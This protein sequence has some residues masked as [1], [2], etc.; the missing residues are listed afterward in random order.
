MWITPFICSALY[1]VGGQWWKAG[2]WLM[3]IP[4]FFIAIFNG[5]IWYSV[6]AILTYFI[7]TNVFS[8]GDKMWTSRIFGRWV[9]MGLSGLAFGLASIVVLGA[10]WGMIQGIIGMTSFLVLKY[11]DDTDRVK[12]PFQEL[13]RGFMGTVVYF[14]A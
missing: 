2:R 7:A 11:L 9:S 6:F 12:N 4:I 1:L 10:F 13:L 14:I 8:Y 3:G 5:H